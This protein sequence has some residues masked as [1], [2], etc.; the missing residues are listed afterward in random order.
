MNTRQTVIATAVAVAL[1]GSYQ[2]AVAADVTVPAPTTPSP[3]AENPKSGTD[4]AGTKEGPKGS[5]ELQT[6]KEFAG[7]PLAPHGREG[8]G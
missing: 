6:V 7:F 8:R 3:D 4:S 1:W 5:T 2:A